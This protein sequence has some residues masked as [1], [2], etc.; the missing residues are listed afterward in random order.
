MKKIVLFLL[1]GLLIL[2][3]LNCVESKGRVDK[4]ICP[5]YEQGSWSHM[6]DLWVSLQSH[7]N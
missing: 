4:E 6:L 3:G 5:H 1:V 7:R 2:S